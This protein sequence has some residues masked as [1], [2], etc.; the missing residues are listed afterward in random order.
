MDPDINLVV[1][2][3]TIYREILSKFDRSG[4][5]TLRLPPLCAQPSLSGV[6]AA[7]IVG[8]VVG[9][10]CQLSLCSSGDFTHKIPTLTYKAMCW[11]AMG[12]P[13]TITRLRHKGAKVKQH[14]PPPGG[15]SEGKHVAD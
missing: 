14:A 12:I 3:G 7:A 11:A 15:I 4:Y 1:N 5:S 6:V 8:V 9:T 10:S 2:I 13:D